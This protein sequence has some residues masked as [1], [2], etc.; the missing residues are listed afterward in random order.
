M[1]LISHSYADRMAR[2]VDKRRRLLAFLRTEIWTTGDVVGELLD[3]R[4]PHTIRSLIHK[5]VAE[6]LLIS[7]QLILPNGKTIKLIGITLN[8]QAHAADLVGKDIILRHYEKGRVGLST[9][10]HTLDLQ[11]LRIRFAKAGWKGWT[12]ADRLPPDQKSR[13]PHRP[14]AISVH[15]DGQR[16]AIEVERHL[17]T[18]K[19]YE[20]IIGHHLTAIRGGVYDR[21][22]YA[23]PTAI[24]GGALVSILSRINRVMVAGQ[25]IPFTDKERALFA[26]TSYEGAPRLDA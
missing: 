15:P 25:S 5:L 4:H 12:Y 7:D 19:R 8:G 24:E 2:A 13:N 16:Y 17:K 10:H 21:V 11:M 3:I 20:A 6:E 14:D 9:I 22:L 26:V 18:K 1:G 23:T